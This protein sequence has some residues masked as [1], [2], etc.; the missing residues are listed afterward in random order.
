MNPTYV[1]LCTRHSLGVEDL[2][3]L[4]QP[5]GN[6]ICQEILEGSDRSLGFIA[7]IDYLTID[8]N[9]RLRRENDMLKVKKSDIEPKGRGRKV[10]V[11]YVYC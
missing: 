6:G 5:D 11:I 2:Y 3:I 8:D 4:P 9:Q 7:T 1:K 10:Q